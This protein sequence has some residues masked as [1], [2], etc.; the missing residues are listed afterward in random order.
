VSEDGRRASVRE[1]YDA[2]ERHD[3]ERGSAPIYDD[4]GWLI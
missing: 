1:L 2:Y 4:I 3:F